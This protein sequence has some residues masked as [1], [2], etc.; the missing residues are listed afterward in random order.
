MPQTKYTGSGFFVTQAGHLLTNAHVVSGC[1]I[2]S[3]K[4]SGGQAGVAQVIAVD[5][6]DDL[7]LLKLST[8]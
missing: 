6:N 4:R 8:S 3:V 7:A 2:V 5:Q 1:T